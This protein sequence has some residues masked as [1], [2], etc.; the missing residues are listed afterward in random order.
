MSTPMPMRSLI[1]SAIAAALA[2][3]ALPAAAVIT[4]SFGSIGDAVS[5]V[6]DTQAYDTWAIDCPNVANNTGAGCSGS[7][8]SSDNTLFFWGLENNGNNTVI[9]LTYT[10]T[11]TIQGVSGLRFRTDPATVGTPLGPADGPL[12]VTDFLG[13]TRT[14]DDGPRPAGGGTYAQGQ[15][16]FLAYGRDTYDPNSLDAVAPIANFNATITPPNGAPAVRGFL[17]NNPVSMF[18]DSN[19]DG[20][21]QATQSAVGNNLATGRTLS[22]GTPFSLAPNQTIRIELVAQGFTIPPGNVP[23]GYMD[24]ILIDF[25]AL[26][27]LSVTPTDDPIDLGNVRAGTTKNNAGSITATNVGTGTAANP[28]LDGTFQAVGGANPTQIQAQDANPTLGFA[29]DYDESAERTYRVDATGESLGLADDEGRGLSATQTITVA[30]GDAGGP[31]TRG[32]TA[33]VVGPILG[34]QEQGSSDGPLDYGSQIRFDVDLGFET[35]QTRVLD[36]SNLFANAGIDGD[37]TRLTLG[38]VTIVGADADR[39]KIGNRGAFLG[40]TVAADTTFATGLQ[41]IFEPDALDPP[42]SPLNALLRFNDGYEQPARRHVR[43]D[44]VRAARQRHPQQ[45]VVVRQPRYL[46]RCSGPGWYRAGCYHRREPRRRGDDLA[47]RG[48]RHSDRRRGLGLEGQLHIRCQSG[49]GRPGYAHLHGGARLREHL[50]CAGGCDSNR[51]SRCV[52]AGDAQ[53]QVFR[54]QRNRRRACARCQQ[55]LGCARVRQHD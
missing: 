31:Q 46:H 42:G 2:A 41:V 34:V 30:A 32:L 49:Y 40:E 28:Q 36:I 1:A 53:Y 15:G 17:N 20:V 12:P 29:L 3:A 10:G 24:D 22:A 19:G 37:L 39:F 26:P 52:G 43:G 18:Q 45:A 11:E 9:E 54:V 8:L 47:E 7:N 13:D 14:F 51:E 35:E 25:L 5:V 4:V 16:V 21:F 55:R 27:Q 48:V 38:D 44:I 33:T 6:S 23:V 50:T